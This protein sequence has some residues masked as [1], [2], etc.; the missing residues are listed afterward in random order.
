MKTCGNERDKLCDLEEAVNSGDLS[1]LLQAFA[2]NVDLTSPLP[3]SVSFMENRFYL[4]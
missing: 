1:L 2:E 3:S 4:Y